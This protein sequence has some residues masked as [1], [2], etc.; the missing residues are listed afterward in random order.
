MLEAH[1][2]LHPMT[3][4]EFYVKRFEA[5]APTFLKVLKALPA[6]RL[7]YKPH[8]RS[9]SAQQLVSTI[10]GEFA[11]CV[12]VVDTRRGEWKE[13]PPQSLDQMVATF[14]QAVKALPDRVSKLDEAGWN[15]KADFYY[16]GKK[17]NES[18]V[19]EFLWMCFF[20]GIHHRGQLTTYLR[21]LGAKVPAIYGPS[22]D[23]KS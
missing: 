21:P 18:P 13:S 22:A 4:R 15:A 7:D 19:S 9:P 2:R 6:D 5:E 20:D 12:D 14:E 3:T 8:D 1:R 10:A 23:E 17:V 16:G 11:V